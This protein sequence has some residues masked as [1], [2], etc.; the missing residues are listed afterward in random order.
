MEVL[1]D[2]IWKIT[3]EEREWS[4]EVIGQDEKK[5]KR[6]KCFRVSWVCTWSGIAWS[7]LLFSCQEV[8][9]SLG[10]NELQHARLPCPSL[11]PWVCSNSCPL[12][13]WC[14]LTILSSVAP[15]SS[16]SQSFLASGS[17]PVN[18]L[19]ASGGQSIGASTSASF[20]PMNIQGLF[21]SGLT[22]LISLLSK[23]LSRVFS[24]TTIQKHQFFSTLPSWWSRSHIHT[25]LLEK[26]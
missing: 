20:L 14:H 2:Y 5:K 1:S 6:C 22:S 17:F 3:A 19:F 16:C 7:L 15:F 4:K 10:P 13:Q 8:S 12:S 25:W 11:A 18:Q 24:S 23:G 9:N 21:P 26:P